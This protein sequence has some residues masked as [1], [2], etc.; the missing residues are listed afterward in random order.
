MVKSDKNDS[1]LLKNL[2]LPE[3]DGADRSLNKG[4]NGGRI[5]RPGAD[6]QDDRRS[7]TRQDGL[8]I[9]SKS[10]AVNICG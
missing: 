3:R 9:M 10:S 5:Y 7:Q 4:Y 1:L 2:I 6:F 8:V